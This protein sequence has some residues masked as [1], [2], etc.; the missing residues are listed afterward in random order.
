MANDRVQLKQEEVVGNDVVLSDINPKS[1]TKSIDDPA[2]GASLDKVIERLWN[3]INNKLSRYV[4]SVN[5]RSGV[6]VLDSSDVGLG[7]VDNVSFAEIKQWVISKVAQEFGFKCI[8]MFESLDV[9][10]E[11]MAH[12]WL[13]DEVYANKPFYARHGHGNDKRGYIGYI[14]YEGGI[15]KR[16]QL[17][18][19]TIGETDNSIIYNEKGHQNHE[20]VDYRD[21]GTIGVNIWEYEDA[22]EVYNSLSGK[23]HSGLRI[24][25]EFVTPKLYKF[26]GVYGDPNDSSVPALLCYGDTSGAK[27]VDI[28]I[29]GELVASA[30]TRMEFK[31]NDIIITNFDD[32]MYLD[33]DPQHDYSRIID[34]GMNKNLTIRKPCIGQVTKAPSLMNQNDI[35]EIQFYSLKQTTFRGLKYETIHTGANDIADQALSV[36]L[37]NTTNLYDSSG[38][39]IFN[40]LVEG[41]HIG[42]SGMNAMYP[43]DINKL[44]KESARSKRQFRTI[45]P[46]GAT[47][48]IYS[49][50]ANT[51]TP[52]E[53]GSMYILPNYSLC[54]IPYDAFLNIANQG[55]IYNWPMTAPEIPKDPY[56]NT[57]AHEE[58]LLG[59]NLVKGIYK[60]R[61][62]SRYYYAT[63][64]SGLRI[65]TT[66]TLDGT[67]L[68]N[69]DFTDSIDKHSGGLSVNV[70]KFLEIGSSAGNYRVNAGKEYFY[71][72]GKINVRIDTLKGLYE[73]PNRNAIGINLANDSYLFNARSHAL[74]WGYN[75]LIGGLKCFSDYYNQEY[76]LL[77]VNTGM[78]A[79]GLS[80]QHDVPVDIHYDFTNGSPTLIKDDNVLGVQ[81]YKMQ[82]KDVENNKFNDVRKPGLELHYGISPEDIYTIL[83]PG[84]AYTEK[85]WASVEELEDYIGHI[86]PSSSIFDKDHVYS[87]GGQ[88]YL[89]DISTSTSYTIDPYVV[90]YTSKEN[91]DSV[92]ATLSGDDPQW[93][94]THQCH[95]LVTETIAGSVDHGVPTYPSKNDPNLNVFNIVCKKYYNLNETP[96]AIMLYIPDV[97]NDGVV[98]TVDS[99]FAGNIISIMQYRNNN[100]WL[101]DDGQGNVR[102]FTNEACTNELVLTRD[103]IDS[104]FASQNYATLYS[105]DYNMLYQVKEVGNQ[106]TLIKFTPSSSAL[107]VYGDWIDWDWVNNSANTENYY[108]EMMH[109]IDTDQS[110]RFTNQDAN[111][112]IDFAAD[113]QSPQKYKDWPIKDAW[114]AFMGSKG[115]TVIDGEPEG[116][117]T[118]FEGKY[119]KGLRVKYDEYR[120]VTYNSEYVGGILLDKASRSDSGHQA[121]YTTSELVGNATKN[122]LSIKIADPSA[123]ILEFNERTYGGLRFTTDGYLGVRVN[124][125]NNYNAIIPGKRTG[126]DDMT[127]GTHGL[128]IYEGNVLGVQHDDSLEF[129]ANGNLKISARYVPSIHTLTFTGKN[130]GGTTVTASFNGA[131]DVTIEVGPGL[132]ITQT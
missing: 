4:N 79:R 85:E 113:L 77:A 80:V 11:T 10:D 83:P 81:L 64:L 42:L 55:Y 108:Q 123:G 39:T 8:E 110:G 95:V 107:P 51:T 58:S 36:D 78:N 128:C 17:V 16:N 88:Y 103:M 31:I 106:L 46:S 34:S 114:I 117:K 97:N 75:F 124:M 109:R 69:P 104:Y 32:S 45:L 27:D 120:G 54:V 41:R 125:R 57:E 115:Y 29:D 9:L 100:I 13:N 62:E 6:V 40:G 59:I 129:D 12:I 84:N 35:Y 66:S 131:S 101:T 20:E 23:E 73:S 24:K 65:D 30:Y 82:Q 70:G 68:G 25:K 52:N 93:P 15:L 61:P 49:N 112:I 130:S 47:S 5:G 86:D 111:R 3:A 43:Y 116:V 37:L 67:W 21:T 127:V 96:K 1:N 119:E 71:D 26:E 102:Y 48:D 63:N 92:I 105:K 14:Y 91:Y 38:E 89:V 7:N 87:A 118:L 99:S 50:N 18:L 28:Y 90:I 72:E 126:S 56:D 2:S 74:T 94:T 33:T 132:T 76:G 19:D 53:E 121:N 60:Q 122:A 22:L 98:T 44:H